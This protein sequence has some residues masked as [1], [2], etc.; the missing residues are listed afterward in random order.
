MAVGPD[1]IY[2]VGETQPSDV[3]TDPVYTVSMLPKGGGSIATIASLDG[4]GSIA[5]D[6][7]GVYFTDS[8]A[9]TVSKAAL[10][11]SSIDV[12]A[13]NLDGPSLIALDADHVYWT[14]GNVTIRRCAK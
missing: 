9:G 11:G 10:D 5:A 8:V 7:S 2:L 13:E 1:A 3:L 14:D 12:I 4:A 6:A